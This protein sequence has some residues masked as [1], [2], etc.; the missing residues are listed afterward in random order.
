MLWMWSSLKS[1]T[2][3]PLRNHHQLHFLLLLGEFLV[4]QDN[5]PGRLKSL[6]KRNCILIPESASMVQRENSGPQSGIW[7]PRKVRLFWLVRFAFLI[8]QDKLLLMINHNIQRIGKQLSMA[9][10][11]EKQRD[12][13][14]YLIKPFSHSKALLHKFDQYF[15]VDHH[16]NLDKFRASDLRYRICSFE[17]SHL[18]VSNCSRQITKLWT[19]TLTFN[20][21]VSNPNIAK[22]QQ[23]PL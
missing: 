19:A 11:R 20:S 9:S 22:S 3:N 7:A 5:V 17:P 14:R 10:S 8:S 18:F 15:L 6:E 23:P 1:L 2:S 16:D 21:R 12:D 4:R 13:D